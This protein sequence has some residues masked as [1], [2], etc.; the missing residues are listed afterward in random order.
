MQ[1]PDADAAH[2]RQACLHK[3]ANIIGTSLGVPIIVMICDY[4]SCR[5]YIGYTCLWKVPHLASP[6]ARPSSLMW[7]PSG[8]RLAGS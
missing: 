6:G 1:D 2:A 4:D 7:Y 3:A 5:G 8:P